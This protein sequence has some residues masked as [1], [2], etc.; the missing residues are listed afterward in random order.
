MR[1]VVEKLTAN[2]RLK[3]KVTSSPLE[4]FCWRFLADFC[5]K[6]VFQAGPNWIEIELLQPAILELA[7]VCKFYCITKEWTEKECLR[8]ICDSKS[9]PEDISRSL[10]ETVKY[11]EWVK[12]AQGVLHH[13][14]TRL[15]GHTVN[16]DDILHYQQQKPFFQELSQRLFARRLVVDESKSKQHFENRFE[17][18]HILLLRYIG[19]EP[20]GKW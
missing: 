19:N 12:S 8:A 15:D 4:I 3:I 1:S 13:W 20:D 6:I 14:H 7:T 10:S 2:N 5:S 11:F 9:L 17:E 18:L 16:Y